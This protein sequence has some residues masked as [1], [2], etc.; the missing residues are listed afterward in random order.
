MP[1]L[2]TCESISQYAA[3]MT[4]NLN[5]V[6]N[7]GDPKEWERRFDGSSRD[8]LDLLKQLLVFDPRKRVSATDALKHG[9]LRQFHDAYV[10]RE[11]PVQVQVCIPDEVR[12]STNQYRERLYKEV[13]EFRK[14]DKEQEQVQAKRAPGGG[15]ASRAS[16]Q[17][18]SRHA[19]PQ[20]TTTARRT[21][22]PINRGATRQDAQP[23]GAV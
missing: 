12:R 7:A 13:N 23:V 5:V 15:R 10:E 20:Q 16:A 11:A 21:D 4:F 19:H 2:E 1:D 18:M 22:E 9:Y 6:E 17:S 3:T 8:S 14:Y